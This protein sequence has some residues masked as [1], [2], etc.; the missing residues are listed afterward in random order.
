MWSFGPVGRGAIA[1]AIILIPNTNQP[2]LKKGDWTTAFQW[3]GN[4]VVVESFNEKTGLGARYG[5]WLLERGYTP[6]FAHAG[7]HEEGGGGLWEQF[8]HQGLD[9]ESIMQRVKK[10]AGK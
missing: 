8:Y 9:P 7:T 3:Q 10:L 2:L 4:Q 5:T 1:N 6:K